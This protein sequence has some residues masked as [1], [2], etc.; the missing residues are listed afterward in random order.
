[1][2]TGTVDVFKNINGEDKKVFNYGPGGAFGELG[3]QINEIKMIDDQSIICM[4]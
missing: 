4:N 3:D 2:L 1:V